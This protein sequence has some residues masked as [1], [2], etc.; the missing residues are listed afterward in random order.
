MA[1]MY[2]F[3][4]KFSGP[5]VFIAPFYCFTWFCFLSNAVKLISAGFSGGS[6]RINEIIVRAFGFLF[7]FSSVLIEPVSWFV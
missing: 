2:F 5:A 4:V 7:P 3:K 6:D 1:T